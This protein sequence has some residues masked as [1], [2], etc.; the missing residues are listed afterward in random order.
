MSRL[1]D[2]TETE[3][4][5]SLYTSLLQRRYY[6]WWLALDIVALILPTLKQPYPTGRIQKA[7]NNAVAW[8]ANKWKGTKGT[9]WSIHLDDP[10]HTEPNNRSHHLKP[11]PP[12]AVR[13]PRAAQI[14]VQKN[15]TTPNPTARGWSY[16]GIQTK[17]AYCQR[18]RRS[19]PSL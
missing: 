12:F 13:A 9:H 14:A 3:S 4:Y 7:K 16:A 5:W 10:S 11:K 17:F 19:H 1:G 8:D 2:R 6:H 18:R 15:A